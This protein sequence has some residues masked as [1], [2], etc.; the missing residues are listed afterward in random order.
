[1]SARRL[2]VDLFGDGQ[3]LAWHVVQ[4]VEFRPGSYSI[5]LPSVRSTWL[6]Y[7]LGL[8]FGDQPWP[9]WWSARLTL[10]DATNSVLVPRVPALI[11]A[12][13]FEVPSV[14]VVGA[15]FADDAVRVYA[16]MLRV[17]GPREPATDREESR[18]PG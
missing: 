11:Y 3:R 13:P 10:A 18:R 12:E 5:V 2:A 9:G 8:D 6:D 7:R 14:T 4:E 15:N 1:M 17:D 16:L